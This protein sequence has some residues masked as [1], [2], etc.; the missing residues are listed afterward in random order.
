MTLSFTHDKQLLAAGHSTLY[1]GAQDAS[2]QRDFKK[3]N[4][5]P[6]S[7]SINV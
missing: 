4:F 7:I 1:S 3:V 5:S 6:D 2:E